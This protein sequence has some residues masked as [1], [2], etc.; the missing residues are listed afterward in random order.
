MQQ[1]PRDWS[2]LPQLDPAAGQVIRP[3][4]GR[5]EGHWAGAPA[6]ALDP[7]TG[8][9][10]LAYRLRRPRGKG[11][12][13]GFEVRIAF[14]ADGESVDDIW[15]ASREDLRAASIGRC[16]LAWTPAGTWRLYVSYV[17]PVDGRWQ[18]GLLE[19][20]RPDRLDPTAMRTVLNPTSIA[21]EGVKDPFVFRVGGLWHMSVAFAGRHPTASHEE[22]HGT[23]DVFGTGLVRTGSGLATSND[24]LTWHW[25]GPILS[26]KPGA[27]DGFCAR[28]TTLWHRGPA[29]LALYDGAA[30]V[31]QNDQER[32]GLAFSLDLRRFHR[33]T[34]VGPLGDGETAPA[35]RY[36]DVLNL[37]E[38]TLFF[39]ELCLPDGSHDLRVERV[40]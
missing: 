26:P 25:E 40:E 21:A 16:A 9:V 18:V 37:P 31:E 6:A 29:W 11:L 22:L 14:A 19:A 4:P 3:A 23:Q 24:G 27:W 28:V 39:Y 7:R 13:R 12:D 34:R 10:Y 17:S 5:G 1:D 8:A 15:S 38:A 2:P 20:D 33:V 30:S 35:A 32:A 36:F